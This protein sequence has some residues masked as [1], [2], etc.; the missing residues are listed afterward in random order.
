MV[1]GIISRELLV[2]WT[3]E[4]SIALLVDEIDVHALIQK[5]FHH[6]GILRHDGHVQNVFT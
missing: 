4:V 3:E 2:L 5:V 6:L 1:H